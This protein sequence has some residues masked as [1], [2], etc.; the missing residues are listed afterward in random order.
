MPRFIGLHRAGLLPVEQLL[1]HTIEL[2]ELNEGFDR[3]AEGQ[4]VR[5]AVVF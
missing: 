3:L 2:D 1:T 4:A 5:Q